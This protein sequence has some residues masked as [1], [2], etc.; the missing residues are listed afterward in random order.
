MSNVAHFFQSKCTCKNLQKVREQRSIEKIAIFE[1]SVGWLKSTFLIKHNMFPFIFFVI[2]V[3]F[4]K[5]SL[6]AL[7]RAN[8]DHT[9][10]W[11]FWLDARY[12]VYHGIFYNLIT[13]K[14][15]IPPTIYLT[16][17]IS[18]VFGFSLFSIYLEYAGTNGFK[19]HVLKNSVNEYWYKLV[20]MVPVCS[21]RWTPPTGQREKRDTFG[22]FLSRHDKCLAE[23]VV[24]LWLN[25]Q[26]QFAEK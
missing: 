18:L 25:C 13:R 11:T 24:V 20:F 14:A 19:Q 15:L 17:K 12:R 26:K 5:T 9:I 7:C 1:V 22:M 16:Y 4:W 2:K 21:F 23:D 3:L 8:M 10:D 6:P